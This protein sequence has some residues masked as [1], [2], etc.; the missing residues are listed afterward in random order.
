[1][2]QNWRRLLDCVCFGFTGLSCLILQIVNT[3]IASQYK[4][5]ESRVARN[6]PFATN[7]TPDTQ[8]KIIGGRRVVVEK[9][10]DQ[11]VTDRYTFFVAISLLHRTD[12]STFIFVFTGW[13]RISPDI[14]CCFIFISLYTVASQDCACLATDIDH[15]VD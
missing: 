7:D 2:R 3:D 15:L 10:D 6:A 11:N 12:F 5:Q 4:W 9:K 8:V 14:R 1:M 13:F